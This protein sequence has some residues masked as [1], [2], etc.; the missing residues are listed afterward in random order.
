MMSSV[1][2]NLICAQKKHIRCLVLS[3]KAVSLAD[4]HS[5]YVISYY[6][7]SSQHQCTSSTILRVN[8]QQHHI[9][10]LM[11]QY[12]QLLLHCNFDL[13][14]S[15]SLNILLPLKGQYFSLSH[16]SN[17]H[18]CV[19]HFVRSLV[20]VCHLMVCSMGQTM[21]LWFTFSMDSHSSSLCC[22][23]CLCHVLV[24]QMCSVVLYDYD[25]IFVG[26][27]IKAYSSVC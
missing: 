3:D 10:G 5:C 2:G 20:V 11:G 9:K 23:K 18:V 17:H 14:I 25:H 26:L 22:C 24:L 4:T 7:L 12:L 21:F 27:L 8:G 1:A 19:R 6:P 16:V 15:Q 13:S